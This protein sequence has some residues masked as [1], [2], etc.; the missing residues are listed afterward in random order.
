MVHLAL[1]SQHKSETQTQTID[2]TQI[3]HLKHG[4]VANLI[5]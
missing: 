2:L 3:Y 1:A 5:V 4:G